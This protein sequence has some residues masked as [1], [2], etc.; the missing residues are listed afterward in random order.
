M[1]QYKNFNDAYLN[2]AAWLDQTK[3]VN[4]LFMRLLLQNAQYLPTYADTL[5]EMPVRFFHIDRILVL[6]KRAS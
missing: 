2:K 1:D 5:T 3:L 6:G 4:Y